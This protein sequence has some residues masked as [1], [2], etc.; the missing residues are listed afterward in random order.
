MIVLPQ[1]GSSRPL[2]RDNLLVPFSFLMC[3][4]L[5]CF[6]LPCSPFCVPGKGAAGRLLVEIK[7]FWS[8]RAWSEAGSCIISVVR[9]GSAATGG[10]GPDGDVIFMVP[11]ARVC[12]FCVFRCFGLSP[13]KRW[14]LIVIPH[15]IP[16][17]STR[18]SCGRSNK[19]FDVAYFWKVRFVD[20]YVCP[21]T[22]PASKA[23][24]VLGPF[25]EIYRV[26]G[27]P[28]WGIRVWAGTDRNTF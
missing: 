13:P 8:I 24:D 27:R 23:N 12:W 21:W 3:S 2:P 19:Y 5:V 7:G 10:P 25:D 26:R 15:D 6:V 16:L 1:D 28:I 20:M 4:Y 9:A 14:P 17:M 18:T 22:P 11:P